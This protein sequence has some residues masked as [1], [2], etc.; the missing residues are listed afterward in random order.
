MQSATV[1][2]DLRAR[3]WLPHNNNPPGCLCRWLRRR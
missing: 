3:F 2:R 1:E